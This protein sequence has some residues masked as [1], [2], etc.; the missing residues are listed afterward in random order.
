M[1]KKRGSV[2]DGIRDAYNLHEALEALKALGRSGGRAVEEVTNVALM[3]VAL[4]AVLSF[5]YFF[6]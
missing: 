1:A 2:W 6:G 5:V 3:L 4:A